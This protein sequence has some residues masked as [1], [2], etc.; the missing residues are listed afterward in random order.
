MAEVFERSA[1]DAGIENARFVLSG[2][3]ES[4]DLEG[5]VSLLSHVTYF[6][7]EI[8]PFIQKLNGATRRRAII[9]TRSV[10]PP[11]QFAPFFELANG[12]PAAPVPGHEHLLAVLKEMAIP[13]ELIDLG[14][15]ALPATAPAGK[16]PEDAIKIQVEGGIRLGW[17]RPDESERYAEL[18]HSRF[19]DLFAPTDDGYRQRTALGA[20]ELIITWETRR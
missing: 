11:N 4:E 17:V 7:P 14:E 15:A 9:A 19:D 2:W 8:A 16:T 13:A 20:R 18:L 5:D 1:R 6:V 12:E 10:P 3:L